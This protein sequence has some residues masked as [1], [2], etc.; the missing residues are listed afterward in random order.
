MEEDNQN[1]YKKIKKNKFF[2]FKKSGIYLIRGGLCVS[3]ENA[4]HM[5]VI[6]RTE[7]KQ[8][9]Y[10]FVTMHMSLECIIK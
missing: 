8:L 10:S 6:G 5:V 1:I 9:I 3:L 2:F 4:S 7:V